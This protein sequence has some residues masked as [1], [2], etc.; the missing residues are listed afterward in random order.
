[1]EKSTY[2]SKDV[3]QAK[4][5]TEALG[6]PFYPILFDLDKIA[7]NFSLEDFENLI[8][9]IESPRFDPE[10]LFKSELHRAAK[11]LVPD[12]KVI[13]LGQGADEFSGGY[14]KYLGSQ[15]ETWDEYMF[16]EVSPSL[17]ERGMRSPILVG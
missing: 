10:W 17:V 12:L 4:K 16:G 15:W 1:M 8:C 5:V 13:L 14:S 7:S 3:E 2:K 11:E 9:L 6:L